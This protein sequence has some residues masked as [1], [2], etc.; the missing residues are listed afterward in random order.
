[1]DLDAGDIS[2]DPGRQVTIQGSTN[3]LAGGSSFILGSP[4]V[5]G[6]LLT[7]TYGIR[8]RHLNVLSASNGLSIQN[9]F[10]IAGDWLNIRNCEDGVA[11]QASSNVVLTHS[12]MVGNR[13]AGIRFSAAEKGSLNVGSS[14]MW[15][16]RYGIL[17]EQG[18]AFA[19]NS[20]FG[21]LAP[22]SFGYY[23]MMSAPQTIAHGNYNSLYLRHEGSSA[24]GALQTGSGSAARTT[25]Y[26]SVS[27]WA[28]NT[29]LDTH[30]L[31]SDP[32][33]ADPDNG[34]FHLKS[35][36]GR[37]RPGVGW[38]YD[39]TSS[40]LIDAGS[41]QSMGWTAEPDPNGR[42]LN[43]GLY[44]GTAEA[45]K[46][47]T[48]GSVRVI[49]FKD[50]GAGSGMI[51][52]T[53]S[54]GSAA[55]N[56]TV[57]IEYSP[58][59]GVTWT[60]I[61]C[62]WPANYRSYAWNSVPYG[63]SALA[64]WRLFC[65]ENNEIGDTS[66]I[67]GLRNGGTIPYYVNDA[68]TNGDVYCTAIGQSTNSGASV[69]SPLDSVERL[70][71]R[72]KIEPG[73]TIYVDT[74]LYPRSSPL[75]LAIPV[76]AS[77]NRLVI[78]GST[79]EAAGGSVFTNAGGAVIELLNTRNVELRDLRLHGGDQGLLLTQSSSNLA[80]RVRSMGARQHGFELST[81]SD[82]NRF[83]QCAALNFF[84]TGFHVVRTIS[85]QIPATTNYWSGGVI[86]SLPATTGGVAVS[87]GAL[88]GV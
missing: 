66:G 36:G 69:D 16:N 78:Q 40:P 51:D 73:D 3:V 49:K 35:A 31:A 52:L 24:A 23:V 63:R 61:V 75:V 77:T 13:S 84:Q 45:S 87:T 53:W 50:G 48:N 30:S 2:Q 1:G 71:G 14:L 47:G 60:N 74:G 28:E 43:I 25:V 10:F 39:T 86:A 42:Q 20:I 19:S 6:F 34:D 72:Y 26:Y 46:T 44:G 11:A 27:A 41:P 76:V 9:S 37:Y 29:G 12:A 7:N 62:G 33:L 22:N 38:V 55:T 54:V 83:I 15:S 17:L 59:K 68:S 80:W 57:C 4:Q 32:K 81:E 67:F 82:Q 79:N 18:Y 64:R 88:M 85:V 58:D 56:Y 5:P 21:M 70:I 8:L 65:M